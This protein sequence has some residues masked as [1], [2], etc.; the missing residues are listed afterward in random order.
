MGIRPTAA[1]RS[2][3]DSM[4]EQGQKQ[5]VCGGS[6]AVLLQQLAMSDIPNR[7]NPR[8]SCFFL[9]HIVSVSPMI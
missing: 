4:R 2:R 7:K 1:I 8:N 5:R 9:L 6:V 3:A